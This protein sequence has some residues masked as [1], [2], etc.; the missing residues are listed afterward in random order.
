MRHSKQSLLCQ[1]YNHIRKMKQRLLYIDNLKGFLIMLVVLGHCIQTTDTY[2]DHN[3]VFRY[4]YSFHMPL[5]MFVSGWVSY[6]TQMKWQTVRRRFVQLIV[7]F[8]AW[9]VL[10]ACLH[11]NWAGL[12]YVLLHPDNGLW[13]LWALFFIVVIMKLCDSITR[14]TGIKLEYVVTIVGLM[15]ISVMVVLKFKLLGFQFIAWYFPFYSLGCF[16]KRYEDVVLRVLRRV[17]LP[18]L[19]LFVAMAYF[20]MRKDPPT[21][22]PADSNV[23]YNY[24]WKFVTAIVATAAFLPLFKRV[25]D[26]KMLIIGNMGG[27]NAGRLRYT[28]ECS[29]TACVVH[30]S[31]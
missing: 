10:G 22:M 28:S 18:A 12:L 20:W 17:S 4:I 24:A 29:R 16:G 19:L 31:V 30:E 5:F 26:R 3:I 23:L 21:F 15:M 14:A 6:R 1:A 27:G 11:N 8:V 9:A 2:Y 25:A 13:F 7:P